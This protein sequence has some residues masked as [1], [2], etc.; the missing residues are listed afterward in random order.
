M[1]EAY[2]VSR[3]EKH[4]DPKYWVCLDRQDALDIA[5]DVTAYWMNEYGVDES[6]VY[7]ELNNLIF[8]F[9]AEAF[10]IQVKKQT[11]REKGETEQ[12]IHETDR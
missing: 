4:I 9:C 12:Q 6:E 10:V 11:I 5:K 1:I 8:N 3:T 2:I 7:R